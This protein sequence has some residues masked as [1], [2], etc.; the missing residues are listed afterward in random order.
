MNIIFVGKV[1]GKPV[2]LQLGGRGQILM[3]AMLVLTASSLIAGGAYSIGS[4]QGKIQQLTELEE[5]IMEQRQ[6][7][8]ETR[9][10]AESNLDALSGRVGKMQANV[11]RLN[12]LGERL[13]KISKL[14]DKEFDFDSQPAYGGPEAGTPSVAANFDDVLDKLDDQLQ[15]RNEQLNV[16]EDVLISKIIQFESKPS[17][18]PIL[19]GWTSSYFGMRTDPFSGKPEMHKGMD[20]AGKPGSQVISVA[21]G[22]V[23]WSGKRWGY[24]NLVE[25]SHGNGYKTRYGHNQDLLVEVGDTVKKGD[26]I[27]LMGSTGRSTGPHVHFEV[28]LNDRQIDPIRFVQSKS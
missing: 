5:R 19:K 16:L 14:D 10:K 9:F 28:L 2:R 4:T 17:G 7:I 11:T 21:N 20:F 27:A 3:L 15:S 6:L 26:P 18:R 1:R 23:T 25:I 8:A 24:G 13:V 22:I 12:A